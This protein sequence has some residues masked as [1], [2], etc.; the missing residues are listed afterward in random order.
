MNLKPG[1]GLQIWTEKR[2]GP[3]F[4]ILCRRKK[5]A[6]IFVGIPASGKSTFFSRYLANT[7]VHINLDTLHTRNREN[8]LLAECIERKMSF[9]VDNT[10]PTAD[11]RRKYIE[12]A[13]SAG[14]SV[15][16]LVFEGN[17]T[18][19]RKRNLQRTGKARVPDAA[20]YSI[21]SKMQPPRYSEGFS[22]L[23]FVKQCNGD[24]ELEEYFEPDFCQD[25]DD[26]S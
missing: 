22:R 11:E 7:H 4:P 12:S 16:G 15:L 20:I 19:C 10:N 21:S 14:Y 24:F 9:A 2:S 25:V 13:L 17:I 26:E 23:L 8:I 18:E 1:R 3:C 5:N 6:V